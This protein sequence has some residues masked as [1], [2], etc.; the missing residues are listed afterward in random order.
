MSDDVVSN[1]LAI[2][3]CPDEDMAVSVLAAN[4]FDLPRSIAMWE[5]Q[6]HHPTFESPSDNSS[7]AAVRG[8]LPAHSATMG[9]PDGAPRVMRVVDDVRDNDTP[10][11]MGVDLRLLPQQLLQQ[12]PARPLG[13]PH[14]PQSSTRGR[15]RFDG[16]DL[17][18]EGDEALF[19]TRNL[20]LLGSSTA[21]SS[22]DSVS[23]APDL[24]FGR[25]GG[26]VSVLEGLFRTPRYASGGEEEEFS[27]VCARAKAKKRWVL[28]NILRHGEFRS[29][30][31]NRDL[32]RD[33]LVAEI[34]PQMFVLCQY[35]HTSVNAQMLLGQYNLS[36]SAIP[37]LL[38]VNPVTRAAVLP[39]SVSKLFNQQSAQ[40]LP[41]VLLER[42]TEF[43][44]KEGQPHELDFDA[45][46]AVRLGHDT[47]PAD[48]RRH[49]QHAAAPV[50]AGDEDDDEETQL[51]RALAMSLQQS[52]PPRTDPS[53]SV[54]VDE[55]DVD[56]EY[57]VDEIVS[58][59]DSSQAP[60]PKIHR[61]EHASS[62]KTSPVPAPVVVPVDLERFSQPPDAATFRLRLKLSG[63]SVDLSLLP[64]T[65]VTELKRFAEYR[66]KLQSPASSVAVEFLA[67]FPPR[68][69]P[70]ESTTTL[71]QWAGVRPGDALVVHQ[72]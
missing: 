65:P 21:S 38:V 3:G 56:D 18:T 45:V 10:P 42:L 15:D 17:P 68:R 72:I 30:C 69:V 32:W 7:A 54:M 36:G 1:F 51:Q 63:V 23:N 20:P 43:V 33:P 13:H 6:G 22:L 28:L 25:A 59:D 40:F 12:Q 70:F 60:A 52:K 2:T 71:E 50:D 11:R 64:G 41:Q 4:D 8:P 27:N 34:V 35:V 39:L 19:R 5:E 24:L 62:A 9:S 53:G 58:L 37:C 26:Q 67:G 29:A 61:S 49:F 66:L 57:E 46:P 44:E 16:G 55:Y 47:P 48:P 14:H 31:M